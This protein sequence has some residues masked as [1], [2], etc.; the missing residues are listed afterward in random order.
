[1][2]KSWLFAIGV[3]WA[4]SLLGVGLWAQSAQGSFSV[5][6]DG[7]VTAVPVQPTQV[8]GTG[9]IITGE[10]F[11]FRLGSVQPGQGTVTGTVVVKLGGV[12]F[13]VSRPMTLHPA[14]GQ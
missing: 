9:A 5:S 7:Q 14:A 6:P 12:W 8:G 2:R 10:N 1:M 4:V 3:V 13:E 11:G